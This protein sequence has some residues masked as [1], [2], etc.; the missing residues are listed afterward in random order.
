[1][2]IWGGRE[3]LRHGLRVA[4]VLV[5]V[6]IC[7]ATVV[8]WIVRDLSTAADFVQVVGLIGLISGAGAIITSPNADPPIKPVSDVAAQ[9]PTAEGTKPAPAKSPQRR[10]QRQPVQ[11]SR[12][13]STVI[14]SAALLF[15]VTALVLGGLLL[16]PDKESPTDPSGTYTDEYGNLQQKLVLVDGPPPVLFDEGKT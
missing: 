16:L 14:R 1:V 4:S 5:F 3:A 8:I 11:P 7:I 2:A 9:G 13:L 15:L 12:W 6:A 10:R